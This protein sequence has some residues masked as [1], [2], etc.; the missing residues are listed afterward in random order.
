MYDQRDSLSLWPIS[1]DQPTIT[2]EYQCC[3]C[4]Q[5]IWEVS[6]LFLPLITPHVIYVQAAYTV[7]KNSFIFCFSRKYDCFSLGVSHKNTNFRHCTKNKNKLLSAMHKYLACFF[8]WCS[9]QI[10]AKE[11]RICHI[12]TEFIEYENCMEIGTILSLNNQILHWLRT[13]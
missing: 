7:K 4:S 1:K 10:S 5:S 3:L 12:C 6:R 2:R 11:V 13:F 8:W 9:T